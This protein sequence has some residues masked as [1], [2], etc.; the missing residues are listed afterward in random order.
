MTCKIDM[1]IKRIDRVLILKYIT[2]TKWFKNFSSS[3]VTVYIYKSSDMY[4]MYYIN[5]IC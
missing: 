2:V 3:C 1:L 4:I 5:I